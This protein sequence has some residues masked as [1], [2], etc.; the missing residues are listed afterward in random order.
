MALKKKPALRFK[1]FTDD[2]EQRKVSDIVGRYDNLR[3]PVSSNKR[4]HGTTPYYGANGVQDYVDGYTHDGEYILI[5]EDG[6]NDLQ[7][8][9]VHYVNGRIWVNNHAHVLQ[10]KTG[11]ADTKFLSYAF[12]QIDISS[13]LVGGGRA[14]LNAGVLM[15]LDLLLPEHKE[16]EKLGNYFSHIDSLI[17]LHQ[18]KYEMLKKIKKSFLEKMFPKNGKRV[19]EL[20]F[21]GFTDDWEQ[22][23]L[24]AIFEEYSDKGH[25]NLS[26]LTIIQGGGTIRRD[27][28]DRN[29]Q[30]D[31][32]SL[33]N[34]KKVETG[35]FIVHLRSFEGGLEKA[36]TSGIISPA[37]HTFH[38]EGTDSRFYYCYFRSERFINH[39]LKPHVY[40]IRDGR[41]IDI[42]GMKTINI[43][44][45]KVEE[46]KA[47]GNYIDCL[48]NLITLHQ[49]KL[50]KL[51]NLKKALLKKMFI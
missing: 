14:K 6:A 39:D 19:P 3:V 23:K 24:G 45:T 20:R 22:R 12:S 15:K 25:P 11:I 40:G 49:R 8:Y 29:L 33:A 38:G 18:R 50:E 7:N 16:Q 26:A 48:D 47:I 37:Y 4:V 17:T 10:G 36:T 13:L 21:S 2:W 9:P 31:K 32:K 44:W 27:D 30:Y 1:G 46:Q 51:Q 34:Y 41:S 43:P 35:D 28:S 42:E 5:A